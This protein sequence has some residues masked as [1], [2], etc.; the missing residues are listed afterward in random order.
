M[1][2]GSHLSAVRNDEELW[3]KHK[4]RQSCKSDRNTEAG[5]C[6]RRPV[7]FGPL[8]RLLPRKLYLVILR[9]LPPTTCGNCVLRTRHSPP[10]DNYT[11][12][13][14]WNSALHYRTSTQWFLIT[15][16]NLKGKFEC[17]CFFLTDPYS[18]ILGLT[19]FPLKGDGNVSQKFELIYEEETEETEGKVEIPVPEEER[20]VLQHATE[21][22]SRTEWI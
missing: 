21:N 17:V 14:M 18:W 6:R 22:S 19:S 10:S 16:T 13:N 3:Q 9:V 7:F 8:L 1:N 20:K 15:R 2:Y 5:F 12:R 4:Y 11:A